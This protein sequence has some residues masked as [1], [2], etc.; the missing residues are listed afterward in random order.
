MEIQGRI[1]AALEERSGTSQKSGAWKSRDYVIE[2]NDRFPKKCCFNVW[3]E[4]IDS[5]NIQEGEELI[6]SFDIDAHEYQGRW[7]NSIR[8]WKVE[9]V[10]QREGGMPD[11][12]FPEDMPFPEPGGF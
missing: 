11:V 7:Y 8:A 9:R 1:I 6:V 10:A 4:K 2:T 12:P 5:F 3:G